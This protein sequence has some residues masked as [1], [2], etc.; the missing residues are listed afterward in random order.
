[1]RRQG[2][3][4]AIGLGSLLCAL[5]ASPASA[6][7]P[8]G[9]KDVRVAQLPLAV[10]LAFTPDERALVTQQ[11]G[12]LRVV[13]NGALLPTP[14]LDLSASVCANSERGLL[15]VAVDPAFATNRHIYLYY[16]F[17]KH[18]NCDT[19][20]PT[21]PVN[22]VSRFTLAD[23]DS[24]SPASEQVLIDNIPSPNGNHNG[25]DLGFG[26]DGLLYASVG[27]G[28]CNYEGGCSVPNDAARDP[29][30]LLGKVLRIE[31]D[32]DVPP[33]NPY[34]A[35]GDRCASTGRT[36]EGRRCQE[37]WASGLRNPFGLAFDPNAPGTR[38]FINDTGELTWEEVDEGAAGA[39]YG[40]NLREGPCV[41]GSLVDCGPPPAGLTNPIHS[42]NRSS[43]CGA[44]TRGTFI[45]NG[46]WPASYDGSYFYADYN[47]PQ[48][49]RL[50][51]SGTTYSSSVFAGVPGA[52]VDLK[53]GPS[54]DGPSLYYTS[55]AGGGELRRISQ[56]NCVDDVSGASEANLVSG[57]I[58]IVD[59]LLGSGTGNPNGKAL[60]D[61]NCNFIVPLGL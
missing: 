22:R 55:A 3:F 40:W 41:T 50:T 7:P 16:S 12:Q 15:G 27:D 26:K 38:L 30:V 54:A 42:Y 23:D 9:F 8:V 39:D 6:A 46:A 47:C 51:K 35:S 59:A 2:V 10:G 43:G 34:A 19:N 58:H 48:I 5:F 4:A 21:S 14:A 17:K 60:H 57:V 33:A 37:T 25:G 28:A 1:M 31:P 56:S 49:H 24:V 53:F 32:G 61:F 29:H 13:K 11:T 44:I 20:T 18:G 52:G 36:T 45:P